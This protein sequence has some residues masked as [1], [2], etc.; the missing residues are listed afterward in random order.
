MRSYTSLS[1]PSLPSP[2]CISARAARTGWIGG[3]SPDLDTG[4]PSLAHRGCAGSDG[5]SLPRPTMILARRRKK[6]RLRRSGRGRGWR[7][8]IR[9]RPV[10]RKSARTS[11]F[12]VP[13]DCPLRASSATVAGLPG[14]RRCQ[15]VIF[16]VRPDGLG[17]HSPHA[18]RVA[19]GLS[20]AADDEP[21]VPLSRFPFVRGTPGQ[22]CAPCLPQRADLGQE[23]ADRRRD[24]GTDAWVRVWG[25]APARG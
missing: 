12:A 19:Q 3:A 8:G 25:V 6:T 10:P 20:F 13:C 18:G 24:N 7:S 11:V 21:A 16:G 9:G 22:A 1:P 5:T 2:Y 14:M 15:W 4:L 17:D 23:G